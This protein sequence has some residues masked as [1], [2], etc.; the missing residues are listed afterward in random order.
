MFGSLSLSRN[1]VLGRG[2]RR[3][4]CREEGWATG[5]SVKPQ[6][7]WPGRVIHRK[8]LNAQRTGEPKGCSG[9]LSQRTMIQIQQPSAQA[10]TIKFHQGGRLYMCWL[11]IG[12]QR[13]GLSAANAISM[14]TH[15]WG[16]IAEPK[17][18]N[19]EIS[20]RCLERW[21]S[22]HH[23]WK[24]WC[25]RGVKANTLPTLPKRRQWHKNR[26]K[27]KKRGN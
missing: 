2:G 5:R 13:Q 24:L 19:R 10:R 1:V 26:K 21:I 14:R 22:G 17:E 4:Q 7:L 15:M 6:L 27:K 20:L 16:R 8:E 23:C 3:Q 25:Q 12:Q 11:D 9:R 18:E